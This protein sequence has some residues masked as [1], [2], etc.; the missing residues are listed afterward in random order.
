MTAVPTRML[1]ENA[2]WTRD[3][4]D[5]MPG[6]MSRQRI[7]CLMPDQS[8]NVAVLAF[9]SPYAAPRAGEY[10]SA[11]SPSRCRGTEWP[12]EP[13]YSS[14]KGTGEYSRSIR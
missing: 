13:P 14:V 3:D 12:Q 5:F 6:A 4:A 1:T 7:R 10:A 8:P 9:P 2:T 11:L